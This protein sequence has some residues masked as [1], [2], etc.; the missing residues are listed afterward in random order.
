MGLKETAI[1]VMLSGFNTPRLPTL[2]AVRTSDTFFVRFLLFM[3]CQMSHGCGR[4]KKCIKVI[5]QNISANFHRVRD[6]VMIPIQF[7]KL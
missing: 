6:D 4:V 1:K 5:K 3:Y 7:N 2:I